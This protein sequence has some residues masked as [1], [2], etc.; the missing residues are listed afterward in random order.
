MAG[1]ASGASSMQST[2]IALRTRTCPTMDFD[3]PN[4]Y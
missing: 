4:H 1:N 2:M 3:Y